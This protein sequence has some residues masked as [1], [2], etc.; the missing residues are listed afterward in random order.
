MVILYHGTRDYLGVLDRGRVVCPV[1]VGIP[2]DKE[3]TLFEHYEKDY[4]GL[5]EVCKELVLNSNLFDGENIN[6]T[7][8]NGLSDEEI[9]DKIHDLGYSTELAETASRYKESTR[10][11]HVFLGDEE[12]A[13]SRA[14]GDG[15][16]VF[17]F[18]LPER[19][20]RPGS[21]E[22]FALVRKEVPLDYLT[23]IHPG[24]EDR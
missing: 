11:T 1:L 10:L 6:G 14:S 15:G 8:I 3:N 13:K 20:L 21:H 12:M 17:K 23:E 4:R 18:D 24:L 19:I 5:V 9:A 22:T 16:R 2:Q 7:P